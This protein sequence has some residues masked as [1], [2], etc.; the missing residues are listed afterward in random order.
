MVTIYIL[1][2]KQ[3][4]SSMVPDIVIPSAQ[5]LPSLHMFHQH[6]FEQENICKAQQQHI[7]SRDLLRAAFSWGSES[8]NWR[9]K[10]WLFQIMLTTDTYSLT[11]VLQ[12]KGSSNIYTTMIHFR[13][14]I[15]SLASHILLSQWICN[16]QFTGLLIEP[17]WGW[18][19]DYRSGRL[20]M[21]TRGTAATHRETDF[22]PFPSVQS[23]LFKI[24]FC[25]SAC[26]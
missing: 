21:S 18:V 7:E 2:E 1:R 25:S 24:F 17:F 13:I 12:K 4:I 26:T 16:T 9:E 14:W 6:Y 22:F 20:L 10:V 8:E 3:I 11:Y 5:S 23:F 15:W 19:S